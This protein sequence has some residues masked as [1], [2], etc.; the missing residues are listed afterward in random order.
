MLEHFG[1]IQVLEKE[2]SELIAAGE[3]VDRPASVAKEL[4][5]NAIDAGA[6]AISIEIRGG[7][8]SY[9]SVSDNGSGI[10]QQE[11]PT[12]FLRHATSKVRDARDLES[13]H[14]LGFRGE[15]L[16][17]I[18]AVSQIELVTKT[19]EEF[20]AT[21]I[22]LSGGQVLSLEETA[23]ERGTT[24]VVRDLFF[25]TPA[26]MKFLKKDVSEANAISAVVDKIA[27]SHPE[28]SLRYVKDGKEQLFTPGD[29]KLL[30]AIYAVY[31]KDFSQGLLQA[32]Y[33]DG[34][35]KVRGY[36]SHPDHSRGNRSMQTFFIN[37]RYVR[38]AT[39]M[40]ALTEAYRNTIMV[41]RFPACVLFL[42]MPA[43]LVDVNVHPAKV[44]VRFANEKPVFDGV[45]FAVKNALLQLKTQENHLSG[46][47][48]LSK[49]SH[50]ETPPVF[51]QHPVHQN[52][53]NAQEYRRL[54]ADKPTETDRIPARQ[55]S[56]DTPKGRS[57]SQKDEI[58][59][60][61]PTVTYQTVIPLSRQVVPP[62]VVSILKKSN[63]KQQS[64][65]SPAIQKA[66]DSASEVLVE[67]TEAEPSSPI[68]VIGELFSTYIVASQ[69]DRML[70]IDKHAAH[71]RYLFN[72]LRQQSGNEHCQTVIPFP[73]VFSSEDYDAL[74]SNGPQLLE[75]GFRLEDLGNKTLMVE[76]VPMYLSLEETEPALCEIAQK[77]QQGSHDL[78]SEKKNWIYE[79][80]A[81]RGAIKAGDVSDIRELEEM[82]RILQE[83][84]EI[85][86]C[87]HGRP[88]TVEMSKYAIEK[89]FGRK[90]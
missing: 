23:R 10:L 88:I 44:E 87:P 40:A 65:V 50:S 53:I 75:C 39:C 66:G 45:Y 47:T 25:N 9:L 67:T 36:V 16:A 27:L 58:E 74:C 71:E 17:S 85:T 24:I 31:G 4:L 78:E 19:K 41:G 29:A 12:A 84:G 7:G 80:I 59:L 5:E 8:S 73:I 60:Q 22:S 30:S 43:E 46:K 1:H 57:F 20:S 55:K 82:V 81:C 37:G 34:P 32:V 77:L 2:V 69:G 79:S 13:I 33:S 90:Q 49:D 54:Y 89:L 38:S 51:P 3:V 26:R 6:T 64:F 70:L 11:V 62:P 68:R 28:I 52:R 18:A 35:V 76:T 72:Q 56:Q 86:H 21:R 63:P 83:H 61:S 14:T 48:A 42:D 15:A